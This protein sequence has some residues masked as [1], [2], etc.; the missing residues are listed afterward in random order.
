MDV[1]KRDKG[2]G[3]KSSSPLK[4][5]RSSQHAT[6]DAKRKRGRQTRGSNRYALVRQL[7]IVQLLPKYCIPTPVVPYFIPPTD[8]PLPQ[9]V[10]VQPQSA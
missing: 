8:P 3:T 6:G 10:R 7:H 9:P 5:P 4:V 1:S 2:R